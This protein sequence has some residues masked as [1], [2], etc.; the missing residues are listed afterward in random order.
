MEPCFFTAAKVPVDC[1]EAIGMDQYIDVDHAADAYLFGQAGADQIGPLY[2]HVSN[3]HATEVSIQLLQ[4]PFEEKLP[5]NPSFLKGNLWIHGEKLCSEREKVHV[6]EFSM[7]SACGVVSP[8]YSIDMGVTQSILISDTA[9]GNSFLVKGNYVDISLGLPVSHGCNI[10]HFS[11][12]MH[13]LTGKSIEICNRLI[14]AV[15]LLKLYELVFADSCH[16]G[17][18]DRVAYERIRSERVLRAAVSGNIKKA[19]IGD[20]RRGTIVVRP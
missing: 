16:A 5:G 12:P 18:S 10:I 3:A 13:F 8:D 7:R 11:H 2:R 20:F 1:I 14:G 4:Q 19:P 15:F 17:Y 6:N 9:N